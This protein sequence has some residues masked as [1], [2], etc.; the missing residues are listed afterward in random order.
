MGGLDVVDHRHHPVLFVGSFCFE[1]L[2]Q[3]EP[4]PNEW[5]PFIRE[6]PRNVFTQVYVAFSYQGSAD[7]TRNR[8]KARRDGRCRA[9]PPPLS[10]RPPS[11]SSPSFQHFSHLRMVPSMKILVKT[12]H[13]NP[14]KEEPVAMLSTARYVADHCLFIVGGAWRGSASTSTNVPTTAAKKSGR[15][16]R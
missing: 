1:R 8:P 16:G 7:D 2:Q 5:G 14:G 4:S 3:F 10:S 6:P 12:Q 15:M 13:K 9:R 11:P